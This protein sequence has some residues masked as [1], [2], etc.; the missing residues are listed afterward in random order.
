MTR[1][2]FAVADA[3]KFTTGKP[4]ADAC[5]TFSEQSQILSTSSDPKCADLIRGFFFGRD[6][7]IARMQATIAA[8][9]PQQKPQPKGTTP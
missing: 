2:F 3:P 6:W 4:L 7:A 5:I 8:I 1:L 9:G